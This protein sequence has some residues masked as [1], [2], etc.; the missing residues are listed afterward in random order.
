MALFERLCTV[1]YSPFIVTMVL[2]C[3]IAIFSYPLHSTPPLGGFPSRY[4][5]TI[6]WEKK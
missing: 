3:V 2:S 5:H 6:W 1:S 4:C